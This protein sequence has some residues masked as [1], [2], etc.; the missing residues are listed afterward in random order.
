MCWGASRGQ[1]V[2][3]AALAT[4]R[5][6]C[7]DVSADHT[8]VVA[9]G[10]EGLLGFMVRNK[11]GV[12]IQRNI[13]LPPQSVKHGQQPSVLL[14]YARLD[15]ID[16]RDVMSRLTSSAETMTEHETE[17][18][19]QHCFVGLLK[20]SLLVESKYLMGGSELLLRAL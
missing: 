19:F 5:L 9:G 10:F 15:E 14:V 17:R 6:S 16:D 18:S 12:V 3:R 11:S 20:A 8:Q 1:G 4:L 2:S 13:P 7:T